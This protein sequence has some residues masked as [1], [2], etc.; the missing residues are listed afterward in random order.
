MPFVLK[1][2]RQASPRVPVT[3][4]KERVHIESREFTVL[5]SAS[6][7]VASC[8]TQ[9]LPSCCHSWQE[10]S[11]DTLRA[12]FLGSCCLAG[13]WLGAV[14]GMP[15]S[16]FRDSLVKAKYMLGA[17]SSQSRIYHLSSIACKLH[18][19][20]YLPLASC[21]PAVSFHISAS[22]WTL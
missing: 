2:K 20:K 4:S 9:Q 11:P 22:T 3:L 17:L 13:G 10:N 15:V 8:H 18:S 19:S 7:L 14:Q 16:S 21:W 5:A 6:P 12:L 1:G